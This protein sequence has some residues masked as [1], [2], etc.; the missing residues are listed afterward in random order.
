MIH[1]IFL[2]SLTQ[3]SLIQLPRSVLHLH[4]PM[5]LIVAQVALK[6]MRGHQHDIHAHEDQFLLHVALMNLL[7]GVVHH[8]FS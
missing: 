4:R 7:L 1:T 5:I 2:L 6:S 8:S 3:S